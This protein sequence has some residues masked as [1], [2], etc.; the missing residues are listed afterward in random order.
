MTISEAVQRL[1]AHVLVAEREGRT[2]LAGVP[3][4]KWEFK[5]RGSYNARQQG[6]KG[7]SMS[8]KG[9]EALKNLRTSRDPGGVPPYVLLPG[10]TNERG[11]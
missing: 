6:L 8:Q 4:S 5:G 11:Q 2:E 9:I 1:E 10:E 3:N 7:V